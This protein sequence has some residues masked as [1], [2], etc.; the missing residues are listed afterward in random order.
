LSHW[1]DANKN[2]K[3]G[4]SGTVHIPVVLFAC[5]V[6]EPILPRCCVYARTKL[7]TLG[8]LYAL[9]ISRTL[10]TLHRARILVHSY[11]IRNTTIHHTPYTIRTIHPFV[12]SY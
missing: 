6:E 5:G 4:S 9:C 11:T 1:W 10:S 7:F 12:H 2:P 8:L 3:H